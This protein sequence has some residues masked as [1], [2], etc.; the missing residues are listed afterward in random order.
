MDAAPRSADAEIICALV[1]QWLTVR[2]S[3]AAG[4]IPAVI[5]AGADE[6]TRPHLERLSDVCELRG[7]APPARCRMRP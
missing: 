7:R 3:A 2:V 1:V 4:T 6:I 5:V